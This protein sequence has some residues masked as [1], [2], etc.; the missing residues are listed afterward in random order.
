MSRSAIR[1]EAEY[2]HFDLDWEDACIRQHRKT[3]N[4]KQAAGIRRET[5]VRGFS[6]PALEKRGLT[7]Y[8]SP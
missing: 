6:F 1:Q 7:G 5:D 8:I 3:L 2:L 4:G